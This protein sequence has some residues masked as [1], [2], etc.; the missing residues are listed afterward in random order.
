M[1]PGTGSLATVLPSDF[2][3]VF[4]RAAA[5][6]EDAT[7]W[8]GPGGGH[9]FRI[10]RSDDGETRALAS[11]CVESRDDFS[12]LLPGQSPT[13][14]AMSSGEC[15]AR[16]RGAAARHPVFETLSQSQ[17]LFDVPFSFRPAADASTI[18]RGVIG[19]LAI[20]PSGAVTIVELQT[21]ACAGAGAARLE[22]S[23]AAA[24]ALFPGQPLEGVLVD[25]RGD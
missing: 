1:Q 22:A 9:R 14:R 19:C 15:A 11:A 2:Q 25:A 8:S 16:L 23:V 20:A 13:R 17:C 4:R 21:G 24:R 6:A 3:D 7:A 5:T 10:C 12:R 18:L